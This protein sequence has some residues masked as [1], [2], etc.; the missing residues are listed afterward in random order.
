ML[1]MLIVVM[2]IAM[3]AMVVVGDGDIAVNKVLVLLHDVDVVPLTA[4]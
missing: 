2:A 4:L 3:L 1:T